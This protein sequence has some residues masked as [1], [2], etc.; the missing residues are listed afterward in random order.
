VKDRAALVQAFWSIPGNWQARPITAKLH[1]R[2][3]DNVT[4][5]VEQTK[6][7]SGPSSSGTTTNNFSWLLPKEV[8]TGNLEFFI[9]LWEG[10]PGHENIEASQQ[11]PAAPLSGMEKFGVTTEPF[12]IKIKLVPVKYAY[13]NCNTDTTATVASSMAAFKDAF[14]R[15]NPVAE[16]K[17]EQHPDKIIQNE[18]VTT[19][20][21]MF[22]ILQTM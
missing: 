1:V 4:D 17:I 14:Y 13:G 12:E 7:I 18:Q 15:V 16:I 3:P 10:E 21:Q 9:E 22:P 8:V 20:A 2:R 19:L 6:T 5:T 11:M